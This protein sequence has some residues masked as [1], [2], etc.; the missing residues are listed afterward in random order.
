MKNLTIRAFV[1]ALAITGAAAT[2]VSKASTPA[3]AHVAAMTEPG[4]PTPVCKPSDPSL[5]GI[6]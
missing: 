2:T 6:D 1:L 3:K 5:C 4:S